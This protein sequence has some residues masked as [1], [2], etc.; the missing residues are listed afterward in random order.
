MK[1]FL[2]IVLVLFSVNSMAQSISVE[3]IENSVSST[4]LWSEMYTYIK[5]KNISSNTIDIKVSKEV[6]SATPNS[7]NWFCWVNCFLPGTTISPTDI[8]FAPGD[9]N[10][11]DFSIHLQP[12]GDVGQTAIRYCAF[13]LNN[14][15]DS[16]CTIVYFNSVGASLEDELTGDYF[17]EFHPNPATLQTEIQFS[18]L[19]N[20]KGEILIYDLLGNLTRSYSL[21]KQ[22]G[23]LTMELD[24]LNPGMYF[25]N[26]KIND[27]IHEIKRLIISN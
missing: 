12:N 24:G 8:T 18:L 10:E 15:S 6:L 9:S 5:V 20:A 11:I 26:I 13:D 1:R 19:E 23:K 4:D 3:P 21:N 22:T 16:A 2:L 17:S 25:A 27:K 14:D 7:S